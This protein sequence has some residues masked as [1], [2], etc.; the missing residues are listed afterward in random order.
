MFILKILGFLFGAFTK[1]DFR[2]AS[3]KNNGYTSRVKSVLLYIFITAGVI[4]F[5]YFVVPAGFNKNFVIGVIALIFAVYFV[6]LSVVET[7]MMAII[8]LFS[9]I[10]DC[11]K[12]GKNKIKQGKE[13]E[14]SAKIISENAS[15]EESPVVVEE[16]QSDNVSKVETQDELMEKQKKTYRVFDFFA[17]IIF[18]GLVAAT[19]IFSIEIF[20]TV[21]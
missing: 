5:E 19:I 17:T 15:T 11:F 16:P 2:K 1:Y 10:K 9:F 20:T 6:Y 4:A 8:A 7:G 14:G 21:L 13:M 18:A 12:A 3:Y